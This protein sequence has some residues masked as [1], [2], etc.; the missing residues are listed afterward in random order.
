MGVSTTFMGR[1]DIEPR[2]NSAE[3]EWLRAYAELD[4]WYFTDPY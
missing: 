1:L 4:R 3:V 2:L